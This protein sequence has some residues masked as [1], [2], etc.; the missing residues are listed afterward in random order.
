MGTKLNAPV[1][2]VAAAPDGNGYW[3]GAS[4]GGVFAVG[5]A[6]FDG[7]VGGTK[8]NSPVV[9]IAGSLPSP[10]KGFWFFGLWNWEDTGAPGRTR[11]C[12]TGSGGRCSIR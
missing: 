6:G 9:G 2:G 5:S 3:E 12:A 7:S 10:L 4:D 11:T 1:V 8:L